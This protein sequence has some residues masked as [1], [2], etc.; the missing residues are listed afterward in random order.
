MK[1]NAL[2]LAL[3]RELAAA[4]SPT[5]AEVSEY[6]EISEERLLQLRDGAAASV[7]EVLKLA[8][9]YDYDPALFF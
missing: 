5:L 7:A 3:R 1:A 9:F 6:T 2:A 4:N 8:D